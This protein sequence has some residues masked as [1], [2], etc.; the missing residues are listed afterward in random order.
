[1]AVDDNKQLVRYLIENGLNANNPDVA[2]GNFTDD[3]VAHIRGL[4]P[5]G[6]TGPE[7]FK[8]VIRLWRGAFSDWHMAIEDLIAEGDL[9]ANRFT[10]TGTHD[11]PLFGIPPTGKRIVVE[12]QELHRLLDGKVAES[13]IV[14]DVPGIL[15][16]LGIVQMPRSGEAPPS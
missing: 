3:Y 8:N 5:G 1:M 4:S 2:D 11:A 15:V 16:Q 6:P 12:S 9:V 14:D 10:T 13:W 7:A